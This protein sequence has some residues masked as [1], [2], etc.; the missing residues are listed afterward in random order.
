ASMAV[1]KAIPRARAFGAF[2][3]LLIMLIVVADIGGMLLQ[4]I[5]ASL[6][7]KQD[8]AVQVL[9]DAFVAMDRLGPSGLGDGHAPIANSDLVLAYETTLG[10]HY[11][12]ELPMFARY[13][14]AIDSRRYFR[15]AGMT[16]SIFP[17]IS[18]IRSNMSGVD[19]G[20]DW[21][22]TVRSH[23]DIEGNVMFS[24]NS[25]DKSL[26]NLSYADITAFL[27][28]DPANPVLNESTLSLLLPRSAIPKRT[29]IAEF[30]YKMYST[31]PQKL[32]SFNVHIAT[33]DWLQNLGA[34]DQK[35][36]ATCKLLEAPTLNKFVHVFGAFWCPKSFPPSDV[37]LSRFVSASVGKWVIECDSKNDYTITLNIV[38][39]N[40]K[41][42][43][44]YSTAFYHYSVVMT[45]PRKTLYTQTMLMNLTAYS[46]GAG[47][48]IRDIVAVA[49]SGKLVPQPA[50]VYLVETEV[51]SDSLRQTFL[52]LALLC[53]LFTRCTL[54]GV[55]T[56]CHFILESSLSV[57]V[58]IV[59]AVLTY[60]SRTEL[61]VMIATVRNA[62][63]MSAFVHLTIL[64]R[65]YT[66]PTM[67][68]SKIVLS[69]RYGINH[70]T[71]CIT[72]KEVV[73]I[74]IVQLV[75]LYSTAGS[76]VGVGM[77]ANVTGD[78]MTA[79]VWRFH[80]VV[81]GASF[82]LL[83]LRFQVGRLASYLR[84]RNQEPRVSKAHVSTTVVNLSPAS[85][86]RRNPTKKNLK[87]TATVFR[88]DPHNDVH[89]DHI[90]YDAY[91]SGKFLSFGVTFLPLIEIKGRRCRIIDGSPL[92]LDAL[93]NFNLNGFGQYSKVQNSA[94][95]THVT[96][97]GRFVP[98]NV[99]SSDEYPSD[100]GNV[101]T[102]ADD[103][104]DLAPPSY[105][106]SPASEHQHGPVVLM[107][108]TLK[109][110]GN[111]MPVMRDRYCVATAVV[112]A[113]HG[114]NGAVPR[115]RRVVLASY[116]SQ[117]ACRSAPEQPLHSHTIKC[118]SAW[119]GKGNF[120]KYPH[121]FVMETTDSKLFHCSAPSAADHARWINLMSIGNDVEE[122]EDEAVEDPKAR[123]AP[124]RA[125]SAVSRSRGGDPNSDVDD[126]GDDNDSA[127]EEEQA[128]EEQ[129]KNALAD[130]NLFRASSGNGS[131][132]SLLLEVDEHDSKL[133]PDDWGLYGGVEAG[134]RSK[135]DVQDAP[136]LLDHELLARD[137]TDRVPLA[138]DAFLFEETEPSRFGNIV[139]SQPRNE[140]DD[141]D[142]RDYYQMEL[143]ARRQ[144]EK[145]KKKMKLR[146]Q[147]LESNRD[148]YAEMAAARLA[149]MRKTARQPK[150]SPRVAIAADLGDSDD[151]EED[152]A[153]RR[154]DR[155][156]A[157]H[158]SEYDEPTERADEVLGEEVARD[159]EP[160]E[161]Q[162]DGDERRLKKSR[163]AR[164]K[165]SKSTNKSKS[166]AED[167][168]EAEEVVPDVD[169]E[170]LRREEEEE[171]RRRRQQEEEEE[172][173]RIAKQKRREER[174][175]RKEQ[176]RLAEE[177]AA[178]AEELARE[179][180][181]AMRLREEEKAREQKE[182]E[183]RERKER[184][185]RKERLKK[186]KAAKKE[187]KEAPPVVVAPVEEPE[188]DRK[189]KKK[190]RRDKY[191]TPAERLK[192]HGAEE[193]EQR[194]NAAT[195]TTQAAEEEPVMSNALVLVETPAPTAA[196]AA[197]AVTQATSTEATAPTVESS[198]QLEAQA[199]AQPAAYT[200]ATTAAQTAPAVAFAATP[201]VTQTPAPAPAS[202]PASAPAATAPTAE[203]PA[204]LHSAPHSAP[205]FT[206]PNGIPYP[207]QPQSMPGYMPGYM[208]MSMPMAMPGYPAY[209]PYMQPYPQPMYAPGYP[210]YYPQ[211]MSG[212]M[213]GMMP[214]PM[215][216]SDPGAHVSPP[217]TP[218]TAELR[219]VEYGPQLP[220]GITSTS[221]SPAAAPAT[222][223]PASPA[224][225]V[226]PAASPASVAVP[227]SIQGVELPDLPD[228]VEF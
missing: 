114:P 34:L 96:S 80:S 138:N 43:Q 200:T 106:R 177:E 6:N 82:A 89:H 175:L 176:K 16:K 90:A 217:Q 69:L 79:Y 55:R 143:E 224:K 115:Q 91:L 13:A 172:E 151:E 8:A 28:L 88:D 10:P 108:G 36:L 113:G 99:T 204:A 142:D 58:M 63:S 203:P 83:F 122:D 107:E 93:F 105:L 70:V 37:Y 39:W 17:N 72:I 131:A 9:H 223:A 57:L 21:W 56:L 125:V 199:P 66:V 14:E 187:A 54:V 102:M 133:E 171:E 29:Q 121:A 68:M 156:A 160:R 188:E 81:I 38:R 135:Y 220:P 27:G 1:A 198:A 170:R 134:G 64:L 146:A 30:K 76:V 221:S 25:V 174:R 219:P 35:T 222:T 180:R 149:E 4:D 181:E 52:L 128:M 210:M 153:R 59:F 182:Y 60:P 215:P 111:K 74:I 87:R 127:S 40:A 120:H 19:A 169:Y 12:E 155:G 157:S 163:S 207:P 101:L 184:K 196:P 179:H 31:D 124:V 15:L 71:P 212:Y 98:S 92:V 67:I 95:I 150:P 11:S 110:R 5:M 33:D 178:K 145:S 100:T 213:P 26:M 129:G 77:K 20:P 85:E 41:L 123:A 227:V 130:E 119:D 209:S 228:V 154:E 75:I 42:P 112:D 32:E 202:A 141:D 116:K 86:I 140:D 159:E 44:R 164:L 226:G 152:Y 94:T 97:I 109:K 166:R 194:K 84:H 205:M 62:G 50:T 78:D 45:A 211:P 195:A 189:E 192:R 168:V 225:T 190:K 118:V 117:S 46:S 206:A 73:M 49:S 218:V 48:P 144:E 201:V 136:I 104:S 148:L 158:A 208:P 147:K 185:E 53:L 103:D 162:S 165:K 197:P 137:R 47:I 167:D 191:T 132:P 18:A 183:R 193:Q 186:A 65:R 126:G 61:A 3:A 216:M 161:Y 2:C 24:G 214:Q 22:E 173:E 51:M 139:V 23:V 7:A